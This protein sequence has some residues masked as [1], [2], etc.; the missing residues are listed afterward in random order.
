MA[1]AVTN[2]RRSHE[3]GVKL[4]S[5]TPTKAPAQKRPAIGRLSKLRHKS[6]EIVHS[7]RPVNPRIALFLFI[8]WLCL[9]VK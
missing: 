9:K 2:G 1:G 6:S 4:T 8:L 3:L 7:I 5:G